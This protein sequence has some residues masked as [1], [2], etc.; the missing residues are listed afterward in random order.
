[1]GSGGGAGHSDEPATK[2]E[3]RRFRSMAAARRKMDN[4]AVHFGV[5][6]ARR[7]RSSGR[8]GVDGVING[9]TYMSRDGALDGVSTRTIG[10]LKPRGS[11]SSRTTT[12]HPIVCRASAEPET[13]RRR[14]K[15][16]C[17]RNGWSASPLLVEI[18]VHSAWLRL[19]SAT[20]TVTTEVAF[21]R[22][23]SPD[24][25]LDENDCSYRTS[26]TYGLSWT[27]PRYEPL[28]SFSI[29]LSEPCSTQRNS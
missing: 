26:L 25:T 9:W 1:M 21:V 6:A 7:R 17:R 14:D 19:P 24:R 11:A 22:F 4:K 28:S 16:S 10:G 29:L 27:Y 18:R 13:R 20:S 23:F 12:R 5:N 8:V 2:S 3:A 15:W